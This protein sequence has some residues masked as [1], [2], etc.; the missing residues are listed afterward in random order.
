MI[1]SLRLVRW[2]TL[3]ILAYGILTLSLTSGAMGAEPGKPRCAFIDIEKSPLGGLLEAELIVRDDTEWLERSE[4]DKILAEK[5]LQSLFAA[6]AGEARMSLGQILKADILI[7]LRSET[8]DGQS[9]SQLVVSETKRGLRIVSEEFQVSKDLEKDAATLVKLFDQGLEKSRQPINHIFAIPPFVSQNLTYEFDYLKSTYA[10]L[11]E[12]SLVS[13]PGVLVVEFEEARALANERRLVGDNEALKRNLP[14]YVLGEYRHE[15]QGDSQQVKIQLKI[16]QGATELETLE[17]TLTPETAASFLKR[18]AVKLA[19]SQGIAATIVSP[20][21]EAEQLGKR[22][23]TFMSLAN[24]KEALGLFE[25]GLLIQP[26]RM[27]FHSRAIHAAQKRSGTYNSRKLDELE[28]TKELHRRVLE[29]LQILAAQESLAQV[30]PFIDLLVAPHFVYLRIHDASSSL[31]EKLATLEDKFQDERHQLALYLAHRY[32]EQQNWNTSGFLFNQAVKH[33][34]P[35]KQY[36]QRIKMILKYQDHPATGTIIKSYAHGGYTVDNLRTVEGR[37]F[38]EGLRDHSQA[39]S[40][41]SRAADK[42]LGTISVEIK[43][44]EARTQG[45]PENKTKLTFKPVDLAYQDLQ[46][47]P[48]RLTGFIG[49]L[50]VDNNMDVY[51]SNSAGVLLPTKTGFRQAWKPLNNTR[52]QSIAYDGRYV[53]LSASVHQQATE[54]WVCDTKTGES[55]QLTKD[56]DLPLLSPDEIPGNVFG[57]GS[58]SLAPVA[59]GHVIIAGYIGR[60]WVADVKINPQGKPKVNIFYEAKEVISNGDKNVDWANPKIAFIPTGM[61]TLSLPQQK[62]D[63][64][65][66]VYIGR[67]TPIYEVSEHALLV[68]PIDLSVR[69]AQPRWYNRSSNID[70]ENVFEGSYYYA[71]QK[72][73][74]IGLIRIGLPG[75]SP[76]VVIPDIKEGYVLFNK[77]DRMVNVVGMDWQRGSFSK[78]KLESFGPVPWLYSNSWGASERTKPIRVGRGSIQLNQLADSNQFGTIA[79]C[80]QDGGAR[81]IVQVLFDGSGTTLEAALA[82]T[83]ETSPSKKPSQQLPH[84]L[85]YRR[86]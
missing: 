29:H 74:L 79:Y 28:K 34:T 18:S 11:I 58:V 52:I 40:E 68:D 39:N 64:R 33:L 63:T 30:D 59:I 12:Q 24:W 41:V 38:L 9:V 6:D 71:G 81:G 57:A 83:Q 19:K 62:G 78:K 4:I 25:A 37:R 2:F 51:Y 67:K 56:N 70:P 16:M 82:G 46:G 48:N 47:R 84:A 20:E 13:A 35:T 8:K 66:V 73:D 7:I 72:D 43:K 61:R 17:E 14:I 32:A 77:Q 36:A 26:E 49:C 5:K 75:I 85:V 10:Q 31:S 69:I 21:M 80:S 65:Q 22:A 76:E 53:W 60:T 27:E 1:N 3:V 50:P 23:E 15:L 55:L 86:R 54:V 45:D 42:L 44:D